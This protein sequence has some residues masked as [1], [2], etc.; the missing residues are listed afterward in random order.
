MVITIVMAL[1][2]FVLSIVFFC[3]K[4][5]MLISGYNTMS[6][7]ER[8]KYDEKKLCKAT[9]IICLI[10]SVMLCALAFAT[11]RF[12]SGLISEKD[13]VWFALG[14]LFVIT[15]AIVI[16]IVYMNKKAKK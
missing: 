10:V 15:A 8:K 12:E 13:I 2:F 16:V 7:E 9:G 14:F 11:N 3:G 1:L 4:G 6:P 5:S